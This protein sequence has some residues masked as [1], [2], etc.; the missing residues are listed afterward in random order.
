MVVCFPEL[1]ELVGMVSSAPSTTITRCMNS[2]MTLV[3]G[4]ISNTPGVLIEEM[5]SFKIGKGLINL[6]I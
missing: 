4:S 1:L 5:K 6:I 2:Q 3:P